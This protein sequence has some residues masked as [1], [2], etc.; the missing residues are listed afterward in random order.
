MPI[1]NQKAKTMQAE[2]ILGSL[3]KTLLIGQIMVTEPHT[4]PLE[5]ITAT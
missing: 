2:M 4:M 5:P 3:E 1:R